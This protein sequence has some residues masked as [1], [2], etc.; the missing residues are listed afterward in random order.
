MHA[1]YVKQGR[2]LGYVIEIREVG[3]ES[4]LPWRRVNKLPNN[5]LLN[6]VEELK[7]NTTYEF[8]VRGEV[9]GFGLSDY[10]KQY[11]IR[12]PSEGKSIYISGWYD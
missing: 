10:V 12:T 7:S 5:E 1:P 4:N 9:E 2:F 3:D 8:R 11:V 6:R